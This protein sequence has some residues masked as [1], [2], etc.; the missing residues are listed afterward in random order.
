MTNTQRM[1][2]RQGDVLLMPITAIPA[3]VTERR[4]DNGRVVLAYGEVTGHAHAFSNAG[5]ALME[6]PNATSLN[7]KDEFIRV[8]EASVLRHE[9]HGAITVAP[10]FYQ[11]VHQ[12]E[13]T[14]EELRNV[15]D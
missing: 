10:G 7:Q 13:Y 15:R 11:I 6:R 5:V 1:P 8:E 4:R 14:P 3:D 2:I 12:Q 9:E